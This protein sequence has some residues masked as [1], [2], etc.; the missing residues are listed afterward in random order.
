MRKKWSLIVLAA[1]LVASSVQTYN[2]NPVMVSAQEQG[3]VV[4]ESILED[5]VWTK[6]KSP[7]ILQ[8]GLFIAS[9]KT[10]TIEPG[11]KVEGQSSSFTELL[12]EGSLDAKGTAEDRIVFENVYLKGT[13]FIGSRI[14][15]SNS[16]VSRPFGGFLLT[17]PG[18]FSDIQLLNNS[19]SGGSVILGN[20][21]NTSSVEGNLFAK[22]ASLSVS[23]GSGLVT[24]KRNTF[25]NGDS[26]SSTADFEMNCSDPNCSAPN[27]LVQENNFLGSGHIKV[28]LNGS[29]NLEFNGDSNYWGTQEPDTINS[30]IVD[31]K[32]FS[33]NNLLSIGN[34]AQKPFA[35]GWPAGE[36]AAPKVSDLTSEDAYVSGV[37]TPGHIVQVWKN[38]DL[39]G[40]GK[41]VAADGGIFNIAIDSQNAGDKLEVVALKPISGYVSAPAIVTVKQYIPRFYEVSEVTDQSVSVTGRTAPYAEL[42]ILNGTALVGS[43]T[44]DY[45]GYFNISFLAKQPGGTVLDVNVRTTKGSERTYS[46]AVVDNTA[47]AAPKVNPVSNKS[48]YVTGTTERGAV[49]S[50]QAGG[51]SYTGAAD[52]YGKF[53]IAIPVQK[54]GTAITV[55]AKDAAGNVSAPVTVKATKIAP[56]VPAVTSISNKASV[57][58][59]T[60]ERYSTV[61]VQI[62]SKIYS[63]KADGYGKYKVSIP[64]QNTGMTVYVTATDKYS[65]VSL[66]KVTKVY[67]AAPNMPAVSPVRYTSTLVKGKTEPSIMAY[68]KIGTKVYSTKSAAD[69]TFNITIPKQK[70]GI[71]IYVTAKDAKSMVSAARVVTV[72]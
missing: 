28:K 32:D 29:K 3:T 67:R 53:R 20:M 18:N 46:I 65:R 54:A 66:A 58:T 52:S 34:P 27:I 61:K 41:A 48:V 47:P 55:T 2:T 42:K 64:V 15:I 30:L 50:V 36:E 7:Y 22:K 16:D 71:K 37:A 68:A 5:T 62:G 49:V 14:A 72:Y 11:V 21:K 25:D 24:V 38:D 8:S 40:S 1:G 23:N 19:F 57:V 35:N 59:G 45:V 6:D 63:A 17:V 60:A 33:N 31:G 44:A 69:G 10:L 26:E 12:I 13:N 4:T 43:G 39:I 56:D 70:K 51:K 9:G